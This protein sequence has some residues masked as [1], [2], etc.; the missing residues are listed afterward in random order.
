M[1]TSKYPRID[2][3]THTRYSDGRNT[4]SENIRAAEANDL[5]VLAITDHV[6]THESIQWLDKARLEVSR[7]SVGI[8]VLLGVEVTNPQSD[9]HTIIMKLKS[10]VDIILCEHPLPKGI[11]GDRKEYLEEV[12]RGIEYIVSIPGIDIL[13]HPLNLDRSGLIRDFRRLGKD[14]LDEVGYTLAGSSVKVEVMSQMYW[15]FPYMSVAKFT[16]A[17]ATFVRICKHH[18]V[19]FTI[20]SDA[21]S[22]CGVGNI[23]WSL[24]VLKKAGVSLDQIWTPD[25]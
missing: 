9:L 17:Y 3:H 4:I 16:E 19:L 11:T 7:E 15:W 18:G 1:I 20:G 6:W 10:K 2:L 8:K 21:H 23:R 22:A 25:S 24:K 12:R 14:F 5:E 13:A